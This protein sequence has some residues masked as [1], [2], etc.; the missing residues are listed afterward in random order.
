[1]HHA[2]QQNYRYQQKLQL[3][4]EAATTENHNNSAK[5]TST[6][7]IDNCLRNLCV[8]FGEAASPARPAQPA[9]LR[10]SPHASERGPV[11]KMSAASRSEVAGRARYQDRPPLTTVY[12]QP[13][14]VG[15]KNRYQKN[16]HRYPKSASIDFNITLRKSF[17]TPTRLPSAP[18]PC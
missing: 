2:K 4:H 18:K 16:R 3:L 12:L 17:W 11:A 13:V 15:A 14:I 7:K 10:P 8:I 9:W 6:T 1:M 5:V